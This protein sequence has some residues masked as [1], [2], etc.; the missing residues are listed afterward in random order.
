LLET[1]ILVLGA[2]PAGATAALNLA[3]TRSV[4]LVDARAAGE[5]RIG[6][7][8]P[9]I[10]NRLLA[11]MGLLE[12]FRSHGHTPCHG[13]RSAWGSAVP[14]EVDFLRDP[15]GPGWH[16][17]RRGFEN[18]L[19]KTAIERGAMC[20]APAQL[21]TIQRDGSRW[22]MVLD[23]AGQP[24]IVFADYVIDAGGRGS[25]VARRLGAR[26]RAL[27][28]LICGWVYGSVTRPERI[29][30]ITY[31]EAEQDGWWYTA[32]LPNCRLVLAFHTDGD[33]P[34]ARE[35]KHRNALLARATTCHDLSAALEA[36]GFSA[37]AQ[38]GIS[39]AHSA[40]LEPCAGPGWMAIGDA[41]ISFDPLS[42][43]GLLNAMF[44]ALAAAEVLDRH[45]NGDDNA[46]H[47]YPKVIGNIYDAYSRHLRTHY[48][49]E[50]RWPN[51]IF[52]QRRHSWTGRTYQGP[53]A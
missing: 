28:R 32:P 45:F 18:L 9:P 15:D 47:H 7:S 14:G 27:D 16:I 36:T 10:L 3:P 6:E 50:R 49:A 43:Q 37:E 25:P 8:V 41:A 22:R 2:G 44:T 1:E 39:A 23:R 12:E 4:V 35:A 13:N 38:S 31:V 5:A 30:G 21:K 20:L 48:Q 51:S 26:R 53:R 19:R 40:L 46:A 11:D 24:E 42:A 29:A 52:W 34:A 17:D 33:L